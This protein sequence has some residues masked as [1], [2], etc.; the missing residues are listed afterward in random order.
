MIFKLNLEKDFTVNLI[1]HSICAQGWCIPDRFIPD[2]E[3]IAVRS[4]MMRCRVGEN[5]FDVHESEVILVPPGEVFCQSA[6][7]GPCRAYYT[8]YSVFTEQLEQADIPSAV[9]EISEPKSGKT[10]YFFELKQPSSA[11][12]AVCLPPVI[13]TGKFRDEVWTL[14]ERALLERNRPAARYQIMISFYIRQ[15]LILLYRACLN[16]APEAAKGEKEQKKVV[17]EA[18]HH[19]KNHYSEEIDIQQL[20]R[21]LFVSY[22]Y[23]ARQFKLS[24]GVSP[25]KYLNRLRIDEAKKRIRT[26]DRTL[27]QIAREVGFENGYYFSRVFRQYE[28]ISPSKYRSWLNSKNNE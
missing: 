24:T 3:M 27:E 19:I 23:L 2:I 10:S 11:E 9:T 14:F 17:Q 1:G 22:Q 20:S 12:M 18:L 8:H 5:I 21:R 15:I 25:V 7:D 16:E 6:P 28:G 4:G 13:R 26:T